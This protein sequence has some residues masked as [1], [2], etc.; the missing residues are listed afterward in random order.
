MAYRVVHWGTGVTGR[1]ALRRIIEHPLLELAGVYV[2]NPSKV[3][4]DAGDLAGIAQIGLRATNDLQS[5]IN[6]QPDCL[7][8][9]GTASGREFE[10]AQDIAAFL[11]RGI[12]VVTFSLVSMCYPPAASKDVSTLI[13]AACETGQSSFYCSGST[14]G[15]GTAGLA[16]ILL[17]AAGQV[18]Q[19]RIQE[20]ILPIHYGVEEAMRESMGMG[21]RSDY[22]PRRF[23]DGYVPRWWTPMVIHA[24]DLL[25]ID[26]EDI[27]FSWET[28]VTP[29]DLQ[30]D[31][32]LVEAGTIGALRFELAG[33]LA[34]KPVVV[35]E[36][37]VRMA[38][39]LAPQW[40]PKN[41]DTGR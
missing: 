18:D 20:F 4:E 16:T 34:G 25:N 39:D 33:M 11:E 38:R 19:V 32:G 7:S 12:D 23:R 17:S 27:V 3:G 36:Q 2:T 24:A 30:T 21:Q 26:L 10:A 28:D 15:V 40:P 14:P 1:E 29:R 41:L 31:F 9:A 8:Y 5:L 13:A 22:V 37:M 6:I 35:F